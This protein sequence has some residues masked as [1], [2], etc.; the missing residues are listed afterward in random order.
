MEELKILVDMVAK[1]PQ[2]ALWVLVGFW[3][4]KVIVVG[5]IFGVIRYVVW[6]LH[7]WLTRKDQN[8]RLL[9]DGL[10]IS[11]AQE[12]LVAQ[13]H[14][15]RNRSHPGHLQYTHRSDVEWLREAI[16]A[17]LELEAKL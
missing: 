4:Y 13:L 15:L 1:L 5:S 16:D 14:R 2:T 11:G 7:S 12:A 17:K 9:L 8:V 10:V 6:A 3:A